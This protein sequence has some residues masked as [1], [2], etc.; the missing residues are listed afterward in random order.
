MLRHLQLRNPDVW[1]KRS[2][3]APTID[4]AILAGK[5][6]MKPTT[7]KMALHLCNLP[8]EFGLWWPVVG[9]FSAPIW[10]AKKGAVSFFV[11]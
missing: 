6:D 1:L 11:W 7:K 3:G 9:H 5:F 4:G 8:Q 10:A 2:E